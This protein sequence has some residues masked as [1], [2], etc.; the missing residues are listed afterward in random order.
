MYAIANLISA[1]HH[2]VGRF[3][4]Q[5]IMAS[6][7]ARNDQDDTFD[8]SNLLPQFIMQFA[9]NGPTLLLNAR[10]NQLRQLAVFSQRLRGFPRLLTGQRA[11]LYR[12]GHGVEGMADLPSLTA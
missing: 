1:G 2:E 10:L 5:C 12:F 8:H 6:Y 11:A 9:R 3:L 4:N 7:L